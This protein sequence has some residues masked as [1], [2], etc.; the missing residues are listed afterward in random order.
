[1]KS[2]TTRLVIAAAF[3][4]TSL[5]GGSALFAGPDAPLPNR[6]VTVSSSSGRIVT[7]QLHRSGDQIFVS[8]LVRRNHPLASPPRG[9]HIDVFVVD[10][11]QR[12]LDTVTTHFQP[13]T[14]P[15]G[16]RGASGQSRY[17]ARLTRQPPADASIHVVFHSGPVSS[18]VGATP[19]RMPHPNS[20]G[21]PD[22]PS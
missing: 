9:S 2:Q 15:H 12:V 4:V 14:I 16:R 5:V 19:R 1:V 17:T 13:R 21:N 10:S 20:P 6:V 3:V 8:G 7:A 22:A 18:K 11:H